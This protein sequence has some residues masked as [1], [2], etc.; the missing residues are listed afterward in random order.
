M[1]LLLPLGAVSETED[2]PKETANGFQFQEIIMQ[3]EK[4]IYIYIIRF[5]AN[6]FF[7]IHRYK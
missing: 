1:Y 3:G 2:A 7:L 4:K 5:I 6:V